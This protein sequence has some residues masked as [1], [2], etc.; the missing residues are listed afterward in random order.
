M[1]SDS[2]LFFKAFVP[3][4]RLAWMFTFFHL[5]VCLLYKADNFW[6]GDFIPSVQGPKKKIGRFKQLKLNFS[7]ILQVSKGVGF[8]LS[9]NFGD[10]GLK[11]LAM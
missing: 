5:L 7:V 6:N 3:M 11:R 8:P 4:A 1:A 2:S 10:T 9:D